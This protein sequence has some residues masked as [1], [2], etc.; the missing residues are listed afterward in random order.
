MTGLCEGGNEP[1][2]FLK[3]SKSRLLRPSE[4]ADSLGRSPWICQAAEPTPPPDEK[5]G[6]HLRP[7]EEK[8]GG[9]LGRN[10]TRIWKDGGTGR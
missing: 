2:G 10:G 3:A 4:A 9:M 7:F 1:P 6:L 8:C 5:G